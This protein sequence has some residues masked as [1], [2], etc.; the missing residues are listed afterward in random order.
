[1]RL[2]QTYTFSS[3]ERNIELD[4]NLFQFHPPDG[5]T[6]IAIISWLDP[7]SPPTDSA[8]RITDQ[9]TIPQL[10]DIVAPA[11]RFPSPVLPPN[12]AVVLAAE[13]NGDGMVQNIRVN[14]SLGTDLD[15]DAIDAVKKWHFQPAFK[16]EQPVTVVVVIG[17]LFSGP[18]KQ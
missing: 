11:P 9:M 10:T 3:L 13:V 14:H 7:A 6:Q 2:E 8:F 1:M 4:P 15:T 5:S 12:S 17:V 16:D 18:S